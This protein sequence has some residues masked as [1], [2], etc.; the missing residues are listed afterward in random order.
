LILPAD[1]V[2]GTYRPAATEKQMDYVAGLVRR[3]GW[4]GKDRDAEIN[5]VLGY[6][7]SY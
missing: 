2:F 7:R 1:E 3:K 4:S 5:K 6:V